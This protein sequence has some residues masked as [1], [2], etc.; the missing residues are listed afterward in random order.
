MPILVAIFDNH[1]TENPNRRVAGTDIMTEPAGLTKVWVKGRKRGG[2]G[3][4]QNIV[5][6]KRGG[7]GVFAWRMVILWRR[8]L[9]FRLEENGRISTELNVDLPCAT[10][11]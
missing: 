4:R 7:K 10:G 5:A 2:G 9:S 8:T 6:E 11:N 3:L 1:E